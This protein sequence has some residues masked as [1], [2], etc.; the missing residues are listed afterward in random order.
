VLMMNYSS[1]SSFFQTGTDWPEW[2]G[3]RTKRHTYVLWLDGSEELYDDEVDPLQ[4]TN[5]AGAGGEAL[6]HLRQRLDELLARA[7]DEF[8]AGNRY[9]EWYDDERELVRTALGPVR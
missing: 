5:L 8:L 9:A 7:D 3:V 6:G 2:R 4:N 1:H